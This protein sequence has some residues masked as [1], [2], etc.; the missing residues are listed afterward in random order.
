MGKGWSFSANVFGSARSTISADG[1][2]HG[3]A[4]P[5]NKWGSFKQPGGSFKLAK[6]AEHLETGAKSLS[7]LQR[8][9][10]HQLASPEDLS[11]WEVLYCGGASKFVT[12]TLRNVTNFLGVALMTEQFNW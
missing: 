1:S 7:A 4:W 11:R 8:E 10:D 12:D 2:L 3:R 5:P 6:S 9:G